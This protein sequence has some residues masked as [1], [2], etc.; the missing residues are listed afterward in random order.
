MKTKSSIFVVLAS[1]GLAIPTMA[2]N[3]PSYVPA[4]GI[5]GWWPFNGNAN[6]ESGNGN[7]GTVNGAILVDNRYNITNGAYSFDGLSSYIVIPHSSM[8]VPDNKIT[9]SCWFNANDENSGVTQTLISKGE[10]SNF[11]NYGI[12]L[13]DNGIGCFKTTN[14]SI[15]SLNSLNYNSWHHI[16]F[17]L[18]QNS[19]SM[20]QYLDG[21]LQATL[22]N[23]NTNQ[24]TSDFTNLL[25]SC[26]TADLNF[27]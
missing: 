10:Q 19:N 23:I 1:L 3:L 9:L 17:T 12:S 25:N 7:N 5:V 22:F 24:I 6:D 11:W 8:L 16:V 2:Q 18:D 14:Y 27:G 4:N 13:T 26:C 20:Y 21:V 15:G